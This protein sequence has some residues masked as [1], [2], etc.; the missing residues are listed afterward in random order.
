[1]GKKINC[2]RY[3]KISVPEIRIQLILLVYEFNKIV[4]VFMEMLALVWI[5]VLNYQIP[6]TIWNCDLIQKDFSIVGSKIVLHFE[7]YYEKNSFKF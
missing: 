4:L 3:K 5:S 2:L 6:K 1:M 7:S